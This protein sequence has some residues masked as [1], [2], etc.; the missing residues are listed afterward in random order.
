MIPL[1]AYHATGIA[2]DLWY[3]GTI[4]LFTS[5][6]AD[7]STTLTDESYAANGNM[8]VFGDCAYDT[9]QAKFG[10]SS[11]R[12]GTGGFRFTAS[13][14]DV[15]G[16]GGEDFTIEAFIRPTTIALNGGNN[17]TLFYSASPWYFFIV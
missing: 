2:Q 7:E 9:A 16:A 4:L 5:D 3:E 14:E 13:A 11:I 6:G 17:A 15:I 8:T 10:L 1:S 12:V